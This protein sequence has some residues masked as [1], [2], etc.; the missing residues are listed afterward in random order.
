MN[1]IKNIYSSEINDVRVKNAAFEEKD[2]HYDERKDLLIRE[3]SILEE[4]NAK[5]LLKIRQI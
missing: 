4:E 2:N 1:N 5:L 3:K